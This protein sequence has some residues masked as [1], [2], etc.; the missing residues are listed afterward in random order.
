[1]LFV[2]FSLSKCAASF[3]SVLRPSAVSSRRRPR[4]PPRFTS[5]FVF[6][7]TSAFVFAFSEAF[8]FESRSWPRHSHEYRFR[9]AK[10]LCVRVWRP[11]SA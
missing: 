4:F 2:L 9:L 10:T 7:F 8:V 3:A 6:A 5:A 1:M 11:A